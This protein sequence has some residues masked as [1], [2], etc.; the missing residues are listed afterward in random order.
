MKTEMKV[1]LYLK[2]NEQNKDGLC[3]L[4]G[5]I[6]IKGETNSTAQFGCKIKVDPKLWNATSQRCVGKSKVAI[7]TNREIESLLLR[8]RGRFD[9]LCNT[10]NAVKADDVKNFSQAM[11][12]VQ[13][14][15]LKIISGHN[16][17]YASRVGVNRNEKS[18]KHYLR[19]Y[20]MVSD[21]I[22]EKY[23]VSDVP[24]RQLDM[25]FM[26]AF[27]MH[28]R[29]EKKHKPGTRLKYFKCLKAIM[30]AA[31]R[32]GTLPYNPFKGYEAEQPDEKKRYLSMDEIKSIMSVQLDKPNQKF[33]RDMFI[34]SCFTGICYCDLC[35]LKRSNLFAAE[36]GSLWIRTV[37][38]KT[39]TAENVRLMDI[40]IRIIRKYEGMA[41]GERL[42]PML[43]HGSITLHLKKIAALCGIRQNVTF[44][45]ARHCF[46]S[47]VC[48]SLGVP[49]ETVSK[50]MGHKNI[51]TTQVYA[52]VTYEKIDRDVSNLHSR[53]EDKFPLRGI[54]LAPSRIKKDMSRR[55]PRK[56]WK[57]SPEKIK[58][59][60][61]RRKKMKEVL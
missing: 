25:D 50:V 47:V 11:A 30:N 46:A 52:K 27:D 48:L 16:E 29:I 53:I 60:E 40:A 39:G 45:M 59:R 4:M 57:M 15:L 43:T 9:E 24:V 55:K 56:T 58:E 34:F 3:P 37:R 35:N 19:L 38:Q 20:S 36:D 1:L 13:L 5:K 42:F 18:Y 51:T 22:K 23:K 12:S 41:A 2:R 49:I 21:F 32:R 61:E 54:E 17:E 31:V 44:H 26:E 6:T 28:L 33:T 8:L 7:S 14:T 10:G